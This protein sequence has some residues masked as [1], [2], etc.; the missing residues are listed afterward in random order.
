[1]TFENILS[2]LF[3]IVFWGT[4]IFFFSKFML[5]VAVKFASFVDY[6]DEW[7]KGKR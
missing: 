7:V 4:I 5:W 3:V 1:M 2:L 6:V